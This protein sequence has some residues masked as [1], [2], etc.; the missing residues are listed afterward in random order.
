MTRTRQVAKAGVVLLALLVLLPMAAAGQDSVADTIIG[1][2][3]PTAELENTQEL[4]FGIVLPFLMFF[5]IIH[6]L[7]RESGMLNE[8]SDTIVALAI[9]AF[10]V[11]S[12]AQIFVDIVREGTASSVGG[13]DIPIYSELLGLDP[14]HKAALSLFFGVVVPVF[15]FHHGSRGTPNARALSTAEIL[16]MPILTAVIWMFLNG[17]ENMVEVYSWGIVFLLG[18]FLIW[19]FTKV[20]VFS[21][22]L[23]GTIGLYIIGW[24]FTTLPPGQSTQVLRTLGEGIM[25]GIAIVVFLIIIFFLAVIV[26][27]FKAAA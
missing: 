26:I 4:L 15:Y 22:L 7:I 19:T 11:R 27:I 13:S 14:I 23:V 1:L 25:N 5:A 12:T 8:R 2:F 16:V 20:G 21:G 6:H 10:A 9:A 17:F 24:G 18:G 3:T